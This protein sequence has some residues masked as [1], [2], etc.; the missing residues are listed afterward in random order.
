MYVYMKL[1]TVL[2]LLAVIAFAGIL[3][4]IVNEIMEM[5]EM[6][7]ANADLQVMMDSKL[8]SNMSNS[9]TDAQSNSLID[10]RMKPYH[11]PQYF[12]VG[13]VMSCASEQKDKLDACDS[14]NT[15]DFGS[16]WMGYV[17]SQ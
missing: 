14:D 5:S 13:T 4:L 7:K 16:N 10:N 8:Q 15:P 12:K 17:Q 2:M 6:A 3:Y 9:V 11:Q 1:E